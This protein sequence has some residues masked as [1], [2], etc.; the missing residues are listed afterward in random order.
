MAAWGVLTQVVMRSARR[1]VVLVGVSLFAG[2]VAHADEASKAAAESL[3]QDGRRLM[4]EGKFGEACPKLAESNRMD[5]G[6]GTLLY[7]G[8]CY[9]RDGRTATAWATFREAEGAAASAKQSDRQLAARKRADLL[10]GKL[11]RLTLRLEK[12]IPGVEVRLDG[13]MMSSA[14]L[15]TPIAVDPGSHLVAATAPGRAAWSTTVTMSTSGKE[16]VVPDLASAVAEAP[17]APLPSAAPAVTSAPPPPPPPETAPRTSAPGWPTEKKVAVVAGG[18]GAASLLVGSFFGIRAFSKWGASKDN[19]VG[20]RCNDQGLGD[21]DG[22]KTSAT[23][24]N[25]LIGVG[26]AGLGAGTVLWL[27]AK[28]TTVGLSVTPG[29]A[30]VKGAFLCAR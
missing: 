14:L 5:P 19:C 10:E 27:T 24:A 23:L 25:V 12:P 17:A 2:V 8:E 7:L 21:V 16:V 3:F 26:V 11:V 29:G 30:V 9:E 20:T 1:G 13:N 15:G 6:V 28:D 4:K 18:V 22:A